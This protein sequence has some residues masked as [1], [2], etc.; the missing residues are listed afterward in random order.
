M[1]EDIK[2]IPLKEIFGD[3]EKCSNHLANCLDFWGSFE[4]VMAFKDRLHK[5]KED[6]SYE[7]IYNEELDKC[8]KSK[9]I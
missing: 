7:K 8:M 4:R 5:M 9:L 3:Y 1:S 6:E 2:K